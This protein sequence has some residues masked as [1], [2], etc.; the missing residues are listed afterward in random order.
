MEKDIA[1]DNE[2]ED[3]V[4]DNEVTSGMLE[5]SCMAPAKSRPQVAAS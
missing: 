4:N 3:L 2:E 1:D 5:M